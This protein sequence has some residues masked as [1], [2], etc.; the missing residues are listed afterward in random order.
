MKRS[1]IL[2][3]LAAVLP[4]AH[5]QDDE[6]AR[7]GLSR[8]MRTAI[9]FYEQGDDMQAMDRFMEI[10][11]KGDPSERSMANEYINL[12]THRMNSG[13]GYS[14]SPA[15]KAGV[16]AAEPAAPAAAAAPAPAARPAP[17]KASGGSGGDIVA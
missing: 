10:L 9:H 1:I 2:A 11:T 17:P 12:I 3:A 13:G 5:A 6:D 4:F 7:A 14:G 15:P 16:A 8:P